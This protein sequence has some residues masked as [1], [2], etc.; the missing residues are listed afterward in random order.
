VEIVSLNVGKPVTITYAG[1]KLVSGIYKRPVE[2]ALYLA[3]CNFTGDAQADLVHHGGR[4]KAV[5][6]YPVEHYPYWEKVL[7]QS[8]H[9][10][11]FGENLTVR[12]M[13]EEEVCI[14]DIY[15][16]GEAVVQVS[17]PRQ[18]CHKLAKRYDCK[19]LPRRLEET[20]YTGYY[21]RV[22]REGW[23]GP[24]SSIKLLERHPHKLSVAF[25]NRI[26]HHAKQDT[27]GIKRLLDVKELSASW[28]ATLAKRLQGV[29]TDTKER[30]E[31]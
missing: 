14:G 26:M 21:F 3:E 8:L 22:L 31:G 2:A 1:R 13:L 9:K 20:G 11:A 12:G 24:N 15:Q 10:G 5:C 19:E 18:P 17:Q 4:E 29:Q 16:L 25:A 28:Q 23:V 7:G 27:T 30:L 6:V